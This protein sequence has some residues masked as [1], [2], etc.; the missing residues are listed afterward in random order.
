M[1]SE[2]KWP[3]TLSARDREE[4]FRLSTTGVHSASV[5]RRAR[6]LLALDT[7]VG[8]VDAKEVIAA[9]LGVSGEMLRLVAKRFAE[10][11]GDVLATISRKKRDLPPVPSP[12]TGEVEARLIALACSQPPPGHARWSLR[13]LEKHVELTEDIP[14]LDHST[15]GRVLKKTELRPH[16]RKCWN[17]PPRANAEFA[18]R[19]EDVLSVYARPHNPAR[20]VVCRDEK[21]FQL[22]GH[23]RDPLPA[24]P[25]CDACQ[26]SEYVRCGTC[27]IFVW[28]EPLPGWRRVHAL[29]QRTKVDW[30]SQVKGTTDRG[31]SRRRDRGAGHGQ[32]RAPTASPR[33]TKPSRPTRPSLWPNA[34][35]STTPPNT[36]PG[37]TSPCDTKSHEYSSMHRRRF[38][39]MSTLKM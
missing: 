31:L 26:D 4:L 9:R 34:W 27:S 39:V 17:I 33:S 21:P 38:D 19:R 24:R 32:P 2:L 6:V 37:S 30:A 20:P 22:L 7:S 8:E 5:I 13:L 28:T 29:A 25:G 35:R 14:N 18:A 1:S 23:V 3:V 11:G 12:V 10:T 36:G 16:L 15:I